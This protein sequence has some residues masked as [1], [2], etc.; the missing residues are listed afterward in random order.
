VITIGESVVCGIRPRYCWPTFSLDGALVAAHRPD[1]SLGLW[2]TASGVLERTLWPPDSLVLTSRNGVFARS[3][4]F[5]PD[6]TIAASMGR[7]LVVWTGDG[8]AALVLGPAGGSVENVAFL[9]SSEGRMLVSS[10]SGTG[11]GSGITIIWNLAT[12]ERVGTFRFDHPSSACAASPDGRLIAVGNALSTVQVYE[13]APQPHVSLLHARCGRIAVS[14]DGH[15]VAATTIPEQ[16]TGW[17]IVLIDLESRTTINRFHRNGPSIR[18]L[19]FSRDGKFLF[20][21]EPSDRITLWDVDSGEPVRDFLVPVA[22]LPGPTER[23]SQRGGLQMLANLTRLSP[24]G[25]ILAR[26]WEN[27]SIG[28]WDA[29]SGQWIGWLDSGSGEPAVIEFSPDSRTLVA[30]H[31]AK[32]VLWD[33]Q[34]RQPKR[35][36]AAEWMYPAVCF[37]PNG[38]TIAHNIGNR[39]DR[40][41]EFLDAE[42]GRVVGENTASGSAGVGMVFHPGGSVLIASSFEPTIR[43]LDSRTGRALLSLEQHTALIYALLITS[44]G[45]T[46]ISLDQTGIVLVWDLAYYN[47]RIRRELEYRAARSAVP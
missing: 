32:C 15:R 17:D 16:G 43:L 38:E 29:L 18:A 45:N 36:F 35:T 19:E 12:S 7:Q 46:L 13:I 30:Q 42:T 40:R 31:A 44:D 24:D 21:D 8:K 5:G 39:E 34:T 25:S 4:A 2:N 28:L 10:G 1:G 6:R 3:I 11:G 22:A 37:S 47:D 9:P 41:I 14:P 20:V 33:V 27:G 26:A 23:P